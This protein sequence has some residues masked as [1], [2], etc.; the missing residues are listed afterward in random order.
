MGE[1]T[2]PEKNVELN[3]KTFGVNTT[4]KLSVKTALWLIT[5]VFSL[6]MIILTY[7]YFD[8]KNDVNKKQ[9]DFTNSVNEKVEKIQTDVTNIRLG[10]EGIKGDIKLI[11]DRQNRDTPIPST[12]NYVKPITPPALSIETSP[13]NRQNMA[14][15]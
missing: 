15:Q 2:I 6:M 3:G 11:L 14:S 5:G 8:L 12:G 9:E 10:Q 7:S 13:E 4:I 1:E